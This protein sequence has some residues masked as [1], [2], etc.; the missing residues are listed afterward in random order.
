M[1]IMNSASHMMR[2]QMLRSKKRKEQARS[3]DNILVVNM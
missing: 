3:N 2:M 1:P